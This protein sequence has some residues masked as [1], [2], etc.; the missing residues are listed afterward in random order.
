MPQQPSMEKLTFDASVQH[1]VFLVRF[2]NGVARKVER[3][4]RRWRAPLMADMRVAMDAGKTALKRNPRLVTDPVDARIAQAVGAAHAVLVE[5]IEA[6]SQEEARILWNIWARHLPGFRP[7]GFDPSLTLQEGK[8]WRNV[9]Y[10]PLFQPLDIRTVEEMQGLPIKGLTKAER[11]RDLG[12]VTQMRVNRVIADQLSQGKGSATVA[13]VIDKELGLSRQRAT[14]IARTEIANIQERL[15]ERIYAEN[16]EFLS[17]LRYTS[18]LDQRTCFMCGPFDGQVFPLESNKPFIPQHPLCRCTYIAVPKTW[19]EL[20]SDIK[21]R[22]PEGVRPAWDFSDPLKP[23][24][25]L[26][27]S[28]T[29]WTEWFSDQDAG[30]QLKLLGR[31]R[32]KLWK[33]GTF[34]LS[35]FANDG[36][37]LTLNELGVGGFGRRPIDIEDEGG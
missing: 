7:I 35:K 5:E 3:E 26:A 34:T 24:A 15:S 6:F 16:A 4:L 20:G 12:T 21:Q 37:I 14:L 9:G 28:R 30:F 36:R 11:F 22:I 1:A 27:P 13:R 2:E 10:G 8:D 23:V 33:A 19:P 32:Y 17:G 25:R 29:T 31:T 18:V